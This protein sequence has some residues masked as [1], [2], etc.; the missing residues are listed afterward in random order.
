MT[1]QRQLKK[2]EQSKFLTKLLDTESD[3]NR[4]E[5]LAEVQRLEQELTRA[6]RLVGEERKLA[7]EFAKQSRKNQLDMLDILEYYK[8]TNEWLWKMKKVTIS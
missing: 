7:A 4:S 3:V 2:H 6:W 5:V 1:H 8:N